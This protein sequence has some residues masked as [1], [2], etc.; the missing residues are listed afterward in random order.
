MGAGGRGLKWSAPK[1]GSD[2]DWSAPC[3]ALV[4][5]KPSSHCACCHQDNSPQLH[6]RLQAAAIKLQSLVHMD[7][8]RCQHLNLR[9]AAMKLPLVSDFP[10]VDAPAL[11]D[12]PAWGVEVK[13]QATADAS[14]VLSILFVPGLA[15]PSTSATTLGEAK[16]A[17][18]QETHLDHA[19]DSKALKHDKL[20]SPSSAMLLGKSCSMDTCEITSERRMQ[21]ALHPDSIAD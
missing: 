12:E 4:L 2:V 11:R 15:T 10:V 17:C 9:A 5:S 16:A 19:A 20:G 8:A 7:A 14:A 13:L 21:V 18:K 6:L 1:V 3:L